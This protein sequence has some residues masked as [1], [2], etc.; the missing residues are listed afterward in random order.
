MDRIL[1]NLRNEISIRQIP[2]PSPLHHRFTSWDSWWPWWDWVPGAIATLHERVL[3]LTVGVVAR[4]ISFLVQRA[5]AFARWHRRTH[6]TRM[7]E[8]EIS[9]HFIDKS[10]HVT[11]SRVENRH[12][13]DLRVKAFVNCSNTILSRNLLFVLPN[14]PI[15]VGVIAATQQLHELFVVRDDDEL[16]VVLHAS[17]LENAGEKLS[18]EGRNTLTKIRRGWWCCLGRDWSSAHPVPIFRSGDKRTRPRQDEWWGRW[19]PAVA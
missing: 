13:R 10:I 4:A 11:K 16:E 3:T 19:E 15:I 7:W 17:L 6:T 1:G 8:T 5:E 14:L 12:A 2:T 18:W 9:K